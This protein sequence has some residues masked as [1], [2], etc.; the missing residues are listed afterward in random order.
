MVSYSEQNGQVTLIMS[1]EDFDTILFALGGY[2]CERM[3]AGESPQRI[4]DL[5]NR[6]N[7]G[8]P[9]Y[10]PYQVER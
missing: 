2:T 5:M 7:D 6:L 3:M 10:R 4:L 8:N 1:R 9:N